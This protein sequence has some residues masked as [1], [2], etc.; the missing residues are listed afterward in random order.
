[1]TN[2]IIRSIIITAI[3][4]TGA[5][6]AIAAGGGGYGKGGQNSS[7]ANPGQ[8]FMNSWDINEDGTVTL[9][10]IKTK[11]DQ[12]FSSFDS[13]EDGFLSVEEYTYFDQARANDMEK[14]ADGQIKG[15]QKAANSMLLENNDSD[16][17][18]RVSYVEFLDGAK[19]SLDL[20]DN[21]KDGVITKTDFGRN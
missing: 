18:G 2:K 6:S 8:N 9:E 11:R 5:T 10:E 21:N 17:D 20:M 3:L 14:H 19:A 1:M 12:V 16:N 7:N 4:A 15:G 13:N